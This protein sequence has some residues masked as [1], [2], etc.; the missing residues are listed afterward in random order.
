MPPPWG[1]S[2]RAGRR[3]TAAMLRS[4][5]SHLVAPASALALLCTMTGCGAPPTRIA[6]APPP[7]AACQVLN[8]AAAAGSATSASAGEE[9]DKPYGQIGLGNLRPGHGAPGDGRL[10]VGQLLAMR[11]VPTDAQWQGLPPAADAE[12]ATHA[13]DAEADPVLRA[14][15]L[16]GL[17]VRN[18]PGAEAV[19]VGLL[20]DAET[21]ATVRRSA[22]RALADTYVK[23]EGP[24]LQ[25]LA[26]AL[27]D[28]DPK[29]RDAVAQSLKPRADLPA[30]AEVLK[31]QTAKAD[32]PDASA[33]DEDAPSAP[34]VPALPDRP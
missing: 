9:I 14:R 32:A 4:P 29:L 6:P 12:L 22:A 25:A 18:A 28:P 3:Y 33:T 8:P 10:K 26:G 19:M 13:T 5:L 15:A 24:A 34:A 31:G 1:V 20:T 17:A 7:T 27:A 30:V 16:A 21:D 2:P 23:G 11:G